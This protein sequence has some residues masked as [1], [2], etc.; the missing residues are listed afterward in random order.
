MEHRR[1]EMTAPTSVYREF[2]PS[3][4]LRDYVR[5]IA[6]FGPASEPPGARAPTREFWL[7][8]E[9]EL[10]P[11]FADSHAS[12]LFGIGASYS[13]RQWHAASVDAIAMGAVTRAIVH[14]DTPRS[15]MIGVYLRAR[16]TSA[17][18][19]P[20]SELTD[21]IVPLAEVMKGA[22]VPERP[23]LEWVESFVARRLRYATSST[24]VRVGELASYINRC[25]GRVSV[26]RM[27]D[28]AGVS[29]QHLRRLFRQH[30]GVSPKLHGRLARFRSTLRHLR[31]G[32]RSGG[33]S[34]LAS[35]VGYADQSHLIAD[36]REFTSMTPEQ[37]ARGAGFHPFIGD[38][39][40]G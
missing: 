32:E 13:G 8:P 4:E 14:P 18:G 10:T 27:A 38:D 28:L 17:L 31:D 9:A 40:A 36:F 12:L 26:S 33:W 24:E 19:V 37:L 2:A 7:A 21:R 35:E 11:S 1:D 3:P 23:S 5:A 6:W 22:R 16:G 15:G 25:G 29:R 34:R 39:T 30:I 20:A